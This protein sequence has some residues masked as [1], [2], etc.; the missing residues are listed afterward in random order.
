MKFLNILNDENIKMSENEMYDKNTHIYTNPAICHILGNYYLIVFKIIENTEK[1]T[2]TNSSCHIEYSNYAPT[3]MIH[4]HFVAIAKINGEGIIEIITG[5]KHELKYD[6]VYVNSSD[7][8]IIKINDTKYCIISQYLMEPMVSHYTYYCDI[9]SNPMSFKIVCSDINKFG[10]AK[11]KKDKNFLFVND[12]KFIDIYN[13]VYEDCNIDKN[14]IVDGNFGMPNIYM[15]KCNSSSLNINIPQSFHM[16][17]STPIVSDF[18]LLHVHTLQSIEKFV[19][20]NIETS[21]GNMLISGLLHQ[22]DGYPFKKKTKNINEKVIREIGGKK[23]FFPSIKSVQVQIESPSKNINLVMHNMYKDDIIEP[24]LLKIYFDMAICVF[25][26]VEYLY[27]TSINTNNANILDFIKLVVCRL[28]WFY[29][30]DSVH[31]NGRQILYLNF[32]AKINT[33]KKYIEKISEP[34]FFDECN[35]TGIVFPSGLAINDNKVM[36]SYGND[37]QASYLGMLNK[38]EFDNILNIK[39]NNALHFLSNNKNINLINKIKEGMLKKGNND[40]VDRE[41]LSRTFFTIENIEKILDSK[42]ILLNDIL[43]HHNIDQ[44]IININKLRNDSTDNFL[45]YISSSCDNFVSFLETMYDFKPDHKCKLVNLSISE[46]T[47]G[48]Y[49]K[50]QKYKNKN[51]KFYFNHNH[52]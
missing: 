5:I 35:N 13:S 6:G 50:Y 27:L 46:Q 4:N 41:V 24:D 11:G 19:N 49:N 40:D 2:I 12:N 47:G 10:F 44:L 33:E 23:Y 21:D 18:C 29:I 32:I 42:E 48:Y 16:S 17:G 45:K 38:E 51:N 1:S 8:R 28:Y 39:S 3:H 43:K 52:N 37:D 25:D 7:P 26:V 9:E 31:A 22:Q 34:I 30:F 15:S 20:L 36:I 14:N